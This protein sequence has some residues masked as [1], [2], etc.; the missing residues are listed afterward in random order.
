MQSAGW[1]RTK[2]F[3]IYYDAIQVILPK[4]SNNNLIL[5]ELG[6]YIFL[7][8]M[9]MYGLTISEAVLNFM[10]EPFHSGQK[11][12]IKYFEGLD[13]QKFEMALGNSE[14]ECS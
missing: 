8:A 12:K 13:L 2:K 10:D 4:K 7:L 9:N 1:E 14:K 5:F 6:I 3:E 11:L